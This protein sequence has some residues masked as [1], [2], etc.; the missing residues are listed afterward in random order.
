MR[1]ILL[2]LL[3]LSLALAFT[4]CADD[5]SSDAAIG[6]KPD[7]AASKEAKADQWNWTNNPNRFRVELEYKYDV[8]KA[9][10][11]GRAEQT[12]WPSDY[13]PYYKDSI[14]DRYKGEDVL[15][16]VEKYD[17]AFNGWTPSEDEDV[18]PM[19][20]TRNCESETVEGED[21][22]TKIVSKIVLSDGE[23][24]YYEDLGPAAKWQHESKGIAKAHNGIDDDDDGE[25]DECGGEDYDGIESWWGL[26]HAWVPAAILEPEPLKAV[27][28]NGVEFTVSDIK[29]LLIA[30]YD[31]SSAHM[32]GG[33]CNEREVERDDDTGRVLLDECRDTNPGAWYVVATN[34]LGI[35]KRAFAEDRTMGYQVWN[36]PILGYQITEEK[37]V[38]EEEAM[39]MLKQP[40]KKYTEVFNS[41]DVAS[42][43]YVKMNS[44]YITE[45][46]A[47]EDEPLIENIA[48]YTRTDRYE[49][50]I[51]LDAEGM[52]IGGEWLNYSN[53]THPDFLWLPLQSYGGNPHMTLAN[54]HKLLDLSRQTEE[55]VEDEQ[56]LREFADA[57]LQIDIPDNDAGGI[58]RTLV[59][60]EDITI[61]SLQ[62]QVD[63]T[64]TWRGDLTVTLTKGDVEV[65]LHDGTGGGADDLHETYTVHDWDGSS[66]KGEWTLAITDKASSDTGALTGWK[67]I[68][69]NGDDVV[70]ETRS[71]DSA[72]AVAIPDND[73]AGAT[74]IITVTDEGTIRAMTVT[75]DI[76]HT[77]IGDLTIT[78]KNGSQSQVLHAREGGGT[79]N[80]AKTFPVNAWNGAPLKGEWTLHVVDGAGQD[81]GSINT[82]SFEVELD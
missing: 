35:Q 59:V 38:T 80:L 21:G 45:S 65:K 81:V 15:S 12:P 14:L 19:D 23:K 67:L 51:E 71:Y 10:T 49:M 52:V 55:P 1:R 20:V 5:G 44:D 53:A 39:E 6:Q 16:P 60:D 22:E 47:S 43:R 26:C 82:W 30:Q 76:A 27:T 79:D 64:H 25:T 77:Y 75:V 29:A 37:E 58:A 17:V 42:W 73:T 33:R 46:S 13:W 78:L 57:D 9:N 24:K 31:R 56:T 48:R 7:S 62:V 74:S 68:V 36:Q 2:S 8:L 34:F 32:L 54:I 4:A 28:M 41:P 40:G 66:A 72:D 61:T 11:E 18:R 70:A 3:I 69:T 63:V 50:I